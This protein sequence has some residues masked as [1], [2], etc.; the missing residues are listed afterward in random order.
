MDP[1]L[2]GDCT[3][4]GD[5]RKLGRTG[6]FRR[7]LEV[8]VSRLHCYLNILYPVAVFTFR[9]VFQPLSIEAL[10]VALRWKDPIDMREVAKR[11][12][13][14][15]RLIDRESIDSFMEGQAVM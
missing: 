15:V 7:R 4:V 13:A 14:G 11:G 12:T 10:R 5:T 3:R 9:E 2:E 6:G 1:H 8:L